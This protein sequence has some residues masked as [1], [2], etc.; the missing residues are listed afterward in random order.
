MR[1]SEPN[2]PAWWPAGRATLEIGL[3]GF[4]LVGLVYLLDPWIH[5]HQQWLRLTLLNASPILLLWLLAAALFRRIWPS[6]ILTAFVALWLFAINGIKVDELEQPL[7]FTDLLL[8]PQVIGNT[9]FLA[10]YTRP[11]LIISIASAAF[12]LVLASWYLEPARLAWKSA[13]GLVVCGLLIAVSATTSPLSQAYARHGALTT[14]WSPISSIK[15]TGLMASLVTSAGQDLVSLPR[16]DRHSLNAIRAQLGQQQPVRQPALATAPDIVV[17]LSESFFDPGILKDVDS[18]DYLPGWCQL[19]TLGQAGQMLVPTY[20]GNTTRTEFEVLTGVPYALLPAGV[21]PY[22][23]VV[24]GPMASLPQWLRQLGYR[25]T[26]IHPHKRTFWQRQRAYPRLGFDRFIA[27]ED[28][29]DF[30][31]KGW[32]L[33]DSDMTD[34]ILEVI[35]QSSDQPQFI[36]AVSMENHGPWNKPRPGLDQTRLEAIPA[37]SGLDSEGQL[38]WRQYIYHAQ[39]AVS[40]LERLSNYLKTRDRPAIVLFF[41]DH[42]PQLATIFDPLGFQNDQPPTAQPTPFLLLGGQAAGATSWPIRHAFQL[43]IKLLEVS[44]LP[45]PDHYRELLQAYHSDQDRWPQ[46]GLEAL[47]VSLLHAEAAPALMPQK[48][49]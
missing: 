47:Q 18:C 34:Q 31:R 38:T 35:E 6:A 19:R 42:L 10:R 27:E 5:L 29:S 4:G 44:A 26:A 7:L 3:A 46:G 49:E 43:P 28:M 41:G 20:G 40:E 48:H 39:N 12:A 37:P 36:F 17:I 21:Y 30:T 1:A 9:E 15:E 13:A 23:S 2:R 32:F 22:L 11:G 25:T 16:P 33:S 8:I 24:R 14:P 45:L